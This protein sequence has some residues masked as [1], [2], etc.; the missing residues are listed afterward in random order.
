MRFGRLT[1]Q[2][3]PQMPSQTGGSVPQNY[4]QCHMMPRSTRVARLAL[5]ALLFLSAPAFAQTDT[6]RA[7]VVTS[8][9]LGTP[10]A[11]ERTLM[12]GTTVQNPYDYAL[13]LG[14][15]GQYGRTRFSSDYAYERVSGLS[16]VNQ[17]YEFRYV[18]DAWES[19]L[20]IS[21]LERGSQLYML[22][23]YVE[24]KWFGWISIGVTR[25]HLEPWMGDGQTLAR[26]SLAKN[27]FVVGPMDIYVRAE[28]E[29]KPAVSRAYLQ[30]RIQAFKVGRV[31][32]L[33]GYEYL[34]VKR[35]N[36]DAT[37]SYRGTV[38]LRTRL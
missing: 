2:N 16:Y 37:S 35:P 21:D 9:S 34:R 29:I 5:F 38:Q 14:L 10:R 30:T 32:V 4:E 33:P 17:T 36:Q 8:F 7:S 24:G 12:N 19:G 6:L 23:V 27:R 31:S 18:H 13:G 25:Q 28:Y 22:S 1:A 20:R 15:N 3:Y 11:R 26:F